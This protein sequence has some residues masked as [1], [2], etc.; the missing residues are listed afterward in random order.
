MKSN[1]KKLGNYIELVS[2][3]NN[4]LQYGE[5]DVRGVSNNKE[6][7]QTRANNEGRDFNTFYVVKPE[8]FIYNSRTS[9]MGDKVGLGFNYTKR[10]FITSFNN[11]VFR[12]K[13]EALLPMYLYMWFNRPEFD[14]YVRFH[15]WG[16]STE[17]FSWEEMC[18]TLLPVPHPDKQ[19]EIVKEYNVIQNRIALNQ[20]LIQKL[21]ETA[22]A[23][24]KQ[25]FVDFEFLDENGK[26]YKSNGGDMVLNEELQKEIPRGWEVSNLDSEFD[27][28]IGRT[29]PRLEEEWFNNPDDSIDW[30]SIKDMAN[31]D[32]FIFT[33]NEKLTIKAVK[34]FSIPKIPNNT[35]ILS[36]KMSVGKL[37]ITTKEMLSNE[38]IAHFKIKSN[39]RLTTEFIY[40]FLDYFKFNA[41]GTTSSIVDSIN[42]KMI[43][44]IDIL[45]PYNEIIELFQKAI[46][47]IFSHKKVKEKENQKLTELK[48]LLLSKLATVEN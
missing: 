40:C 46:S 15:S 32:T 7:I 35:T 9:R 19:R 11:T 23:I 16:S 2:C 4:K 24:Y 10:T 33:T 41:L 48:D 8:E 30:I 47:N 43:K 12:V 39:T 25:W 3:L 14:R 27:I 45:I 44:E 22:Q 17:I 20:Q 5:T 37:A 42:T 36:F 6:I 1:Y 21:E 18:N 31:C 34:R 28:T 29:P 13:D 38:A 26:P